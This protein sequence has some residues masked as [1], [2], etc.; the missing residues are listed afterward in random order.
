MFLSFFHLITN[1]LWSNFFLVRVSAM[2]L[3]YFFSFFIYSWPAVRQTIFKTVMSHKLKLPK[4]V[5]IMTSLGNSHL[6]PLFNFCS[7]IILLCYDK[8][9]CDRALRFLPGVITKRHTWQL[10]TNPLSNKEVSVSAAASLSSCSTSYW[11]RINKEKSFALNS[12][13]DQSLCTVGSHKAP[14]GEQK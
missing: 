13:A 6:D 5:T 3:T 7:L 4:E 12:Q 9:A 11:A 2:A 1:L 14:L 8:L 10:I